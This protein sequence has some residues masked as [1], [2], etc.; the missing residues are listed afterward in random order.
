LTA[1][2]HIQLLL[3]AKQ[4][5]IPFQALPGISLT[6]YVSL[7]GLQEYKLG[8]IITIPFWEENFKPESFYDKFLEN[9]LLGLH[10]LC[11]LDIKKEKNKMMTVQEALKV[12][13]EI[14][15][16]R[17]LSTIKNSLLVVISAAGA[18][19]QRISSGSPADL[20][21]QRFPVPASIIICGKLNDKETEALHAL[22]GLKG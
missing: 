4:K 15:D 18:K 22:A 19:N 13:Q 16:K 9:Q 12:L 6:N 11:L 7:T 2:T 5:K 10:T 8:Q 14:E 3:D 1:T 21:N 17:H 20:M